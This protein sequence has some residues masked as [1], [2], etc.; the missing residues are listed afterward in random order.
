M[1]NLPEQMP[2]GYVETGLLFCDVETT[3][4]LHI[5]TVDP[6][7]REPLVFLGVFLSDEEEP[8]TEFSAGCL[9][10]TAAKARAAAAALL[11]AADTL[12]GTTKLSFMPKC[13]LPGHIGREPRR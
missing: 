6:R 5:G 10:F 12:D 11:N 8:E 1:P 7:T 9:L 2:D 13:S 3:D 4:R